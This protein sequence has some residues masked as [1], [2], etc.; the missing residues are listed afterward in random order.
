MFKRISYRGIDS[1][2]I[3]PSHCLL[4]YPLSTYSSLLCTDL[5]SQWDE[6][7]GSLEDPVEDSEDGGMLIHP[8]GR[9][10]DGDDDALLGCMTAGDD[11][12]EMMKEPFRGRGSE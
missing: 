5:R 12:D 8:A 1:E 6:S 3:E 11:T 10:G 7:L 9:G 2:D 4:H